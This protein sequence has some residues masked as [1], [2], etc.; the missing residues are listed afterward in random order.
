[1]NSSTGLPSDRSEQENPH[2]GDILVVDDKPNNLRLLNIMLGKNGYKVREA[3]SGQIALQEVHT[4][5][6]DLILLDI[7]MPEMNGY[8]VC[9]QLKASAS[10]AVIPIIFL[11]ALN[12]T[13]DKVKAFEAGGVDYITKP[14]Q[15]QEVLARVKTQLILRRQQVM[16]QEEICDRQKAETSLQEVNLTLEQRV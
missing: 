10:T 9:R 6:P 1:M 3:T 15:L 14:F 13:F 4:H 7:L 12:D 16:L 11:S 8:E 5:P 2:K